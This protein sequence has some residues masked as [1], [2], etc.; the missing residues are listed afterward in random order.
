MLEGGRRVLIRIARVQEVRVVFME[1]G[2]LTA[3]AKLEEVALENL[4]VCRL[5]G[6]VVYANGCPDGEAVRVHL[7]VVV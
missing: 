7:A 5:V 6:R 4:L 3:L 2:S 1:V